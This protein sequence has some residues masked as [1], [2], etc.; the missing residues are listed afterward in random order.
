MSGT[1]ELQPLT[2]E[3]R[4]AVCIARHTTVACFVAVLVVDMIGACMLCGIDAVG[5]V[6]A[7]VQYSSTRQCLY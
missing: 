1:I 5:H 6:A 3:D 2:Q 4:T 7:A